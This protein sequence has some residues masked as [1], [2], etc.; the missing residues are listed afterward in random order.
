MAAPYRRYLLALLIDVTHW[1]Q[2]RT[3]SSTRPAT[4]GFNGSN[5]RERMLPR[6]DARDAMPYGRVDAQTQDVR[7]RGAAEWR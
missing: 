1:R 6:V 5:R 3:C 7:K 4:L 2:V